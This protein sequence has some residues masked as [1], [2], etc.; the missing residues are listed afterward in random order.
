MRIRGRWFIWLQAAAIVFVSRLLFK[1]LRIYFLPAAPNTNPYSNDGS[2]GFIYSVW[3][4][5]VA[6]P[7]FAGRHV[8][9]VAL[10]SKH[11]DNSPLVLGLQMLGI[12]IVRGSSGR[13]GVEAIRELLRTPSNSHLV[14]TPDGPRGPRHQVKPGL[15]L[16]AARSGRAIVPTA[17]VSSRCWR[18]PGRWTDLVIP[19]PFARAYALGGR[20]IYVAKDAT[21]R[22]FTLS[23]LE[24]QAEMDRLSALAAELARRNCRTDAE[25]AA[26]LTDSQERV[27]A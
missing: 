12:G 10:V 22:E 25:I 2:E 17:F 26:V 6:F 27:A 5:E 19:K 7:M 9:T 21:Q 8:R 16:M 13:N 18:I 23:L 1:T 4:D 14:I 20:P 3:H 15:V 11:A 24:V